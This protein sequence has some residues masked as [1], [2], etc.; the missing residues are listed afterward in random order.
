MTLSHARLH[1]RWLLV[2]Q[3]R[4]RFHLQ[5]TAS[6]ACPALPFPF[7]GRCVGRQVT[8]TA[9]SSC[10]ALP[11]T[12]HARSVN[13]CPFSTPTDGLAPHCRYRAQM[14]FAQGCIDCPPQSRGPCLPCTCRSRSVGGARGGRGEGPCLPRTAVPVRWAVRGEIRPRA[15][16]GSLRSTEN[17][18][19]TRSIL[20]C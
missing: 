7:G 20:L 4:C 19:E 9:L 18:A 6:L 3:I 1:L 2:P 12:F 13:R 14:R 16:A 10:L 8:P 5:E 11:S 15:D 17:V